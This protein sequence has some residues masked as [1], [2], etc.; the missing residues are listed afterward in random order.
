MTKTLRKALRPLPVG[1]NAVLAPILAK[2]FTKRRLLQEA[3]AGWRHQEDR[4]DMQRTVTALQELLESYN[5]NQTPAELEDLY[6]HP[7]SI[8]RCAR[9]LWLAHYNAPT[10]PESAETTVRRWMTLTIG[11]LLHLAVQNA[12]DAAGIL[13]EREKALLSHKY[14]I[15]G[16]ADGVLKIKG[17]EWLLEIKTIN[18]RRFKE[19]ALK[20]TPEYVWQIMCYLKVLNLDRAIL[21]YVCK[22]TGAVAEHLVWFSQKVWEQ[23]CLP[24]IQTHLSA[25]KAKVLPK[26]PYNTPT[27]FPCSFCPFVPLCFSAGKAEA[28]AKE[29]ICE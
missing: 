23:E 13:V 16:H 9:Q 22:D 5:H 21:F 19:A 7:S 27:Q 29:V 25:V 8:G 10:E 6:F 11:S 24:R 4:A 28:F 3:L 12:C 26:R 20:P 2:Y 15:I 18:A 14:K 17:V 1:S